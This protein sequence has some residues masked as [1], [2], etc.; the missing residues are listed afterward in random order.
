MF[1]NLLILASVL[2]LFNCNKNKTTATPAPT[3]TPTTPANAP[4]YF[5]YK[6]ETEC[7]NSTAGSP[8]NITSGTLTIRFFKNG[9][10]GTVVPT[11]GYAYADS[12]KF[13]N[14]LLSAGSDTIYSFVQTN[15]IFNPNRAISFNYPGKVG[16]FSDVEMDTIPLWKE[17]IYLPDSLDRNTAN[18]FYVNGIPASYFPFSNTQAIITIS[19]ETLPAANTVTLSA[20]LGSYTA[21]YPTGSLLGLNAN[22]QGA[23]KIDISEFDLYSDPSISIMTQRV[24]HYTKKIKLK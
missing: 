10:T 22:S 13:N 4:C 14:V 23:I 12:V 17:Y 11:S 7:R 9:F 21:S 3:P 2:F 6:F 19:D 18:G 8:M 20:Q 5:V 16:S 1:K 24:H 15:N